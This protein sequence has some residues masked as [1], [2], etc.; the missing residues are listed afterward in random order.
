MAR[1]WIILALRLGL[2]GSAREE[3]PEFVQHALAFATHGASI[4]TG[5][6]ESAG[7]LRLGKTT[8][9]LVVGAE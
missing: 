4:V 3:A 7:T 8:R 6:S 1:R 5:D 9:A 2:S